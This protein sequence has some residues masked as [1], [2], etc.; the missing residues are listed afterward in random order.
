MKLSSLNK[1]IK[2]CKKKLRQTEK[3]CR[4][5]DSSLNKTRKKSEIF[6]KKTKFLKR[7]YW[8]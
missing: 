7:T 6:K 2:V 4:S 3:L 1:I 8:T 5:L